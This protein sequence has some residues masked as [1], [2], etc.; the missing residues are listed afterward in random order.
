M[1]AMT[2]HHPPWF[3]AAGL[4]HFVVDA[5]GCLHP[6]PSYWTHSLGAPELALVEESCCAERALH[7]ALRAD[8]LHPVT[9]AALAALADPDVTDNYRW[10]LRARDE[11]LLAGSLQAAYRRCTGPDAPPMAPVLVAQ[12]VQTLLAHLLRDEPDALVWRAAELLFRPQRIALEAGRVLAADLVTLD[13]AA[14]STGVLFDLQAL[15]GQAGAAQSG[16][17]LRVLERTDQSE[18]DYFAKQGAFGHYGA[19]LDLTLELQQQLS[20]GLRLTTQNSHGGLLALAQVLQRWVA[21]F[22]GLAVLIEPLARIDDPAWRWHLGLDAAASG[23]LDTLYRGQVLTPAQSAQLLGLFR[24]RF[25]QPQAMLV[26]GRGKPVYLGLAQDG[27]G[28]LRLKAHNLL[29]NLPVG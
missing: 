7:A 1:A 5:A 23:L 13:T 17:R 25:K 19:V 11:L 3:D 24:L 21:H 22:L 8:P 14:S 6:L 28:I 12:W 18:A 16:Q 9:E 27:K 10:W 15:L 20:H 26:D 2:A 4:S 29:L